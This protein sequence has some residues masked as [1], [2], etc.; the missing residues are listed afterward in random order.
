MKVKLLNSNIRT[1]F[2][3]PSD[4]LRATIHF[5][6]IYFPII[7]YSVQSPQPISPHSHSSRS[8]NAV[9]PNS[10]IWPELER[11]QN[12]ASNHASQDGPYQRT[13]WLLSAFL[14]HQICFNVKATWLYFCLTFFPALKK[15]FYTLVM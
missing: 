10:V 3:R 6:H 14:Y 4:F 7:R 1:Y 5:P 12:S 8:D 15:R 13:H 11:E 2:T 9:R